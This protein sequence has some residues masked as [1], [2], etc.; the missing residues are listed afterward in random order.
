MRAFAWFLAAIAGSLL[1][2]ALLA[3]PAYLLLHP[4]FPSWWFEKI[5]TR[6]FQ[7]F[8]L[9]AVIW[10]VRRLRLNSKR[11]WGYGVPRIRWRRQFLVGL[12]AGLATML[13]VTLSMLAFG[14]RGLN[15]GFSGAM[16]LHASL[17]G[18]GSGL[19]VG[20]V[21]E[22][23]FRGLM[24]GAVLRESRRPLL[25]IVLVSVVY[26]ALHF[27]ARVRIPHEAVTAHS[28]LDLLAQAF[29]NFAAPATIAD[30]FLALVAVGLLTGLATWWTGSIALAAGLHAGWVWMMRT[31]VGVTRLDPAA[32]YAW[33]VSH[34]DGYTGWL[35]L[36]WTLLLLLVL[37]ASRRRFSSWRA[38]Q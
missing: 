29:A 1:A 4:H 24:Q 23:F 33:L 36:L 35:V 25:A 15:P 38:R 2:A 21:E 13:P 28:G 20:F 5:A 26:S 3:Y 37:S 19:A 30:S 22:T 12:A 31:T 8:A 11:D 32:R 18:L 34:S 6:L 10:L 7:L 9:L 16:L 14:V 27:L 17:A